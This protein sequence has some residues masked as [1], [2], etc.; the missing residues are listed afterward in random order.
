MRIVTTEHLVDRLDSDLAWRKKELTALGFVLK[1]SGA[2][3]GQAL[4]RGAVTL[5]YAH[6]EGYIKAAALG[7]VE[8]VGS[9]RLRNR[10]LADNFLAL[11]CRALLRSGAESGRIGP[12]L[13]VISFLRN[14][15][16]ERS[17][18]PAKSIE[19][20]SN[21]SSSVFREIT[22]VLGL[23]YEPYETKAVLID[24]SLLHARN[25]IAHGEYVLV[26]MDRWDELHHEVLTL[27]ESF[28]TDVMNAA[29]LERYRLGS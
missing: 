23:N 29:V 5:L 7:Y 22:A 26:T 20:R 2:D 8:F 1:T 6:W 12:H 25:T 10:E 19:T 11:A 27:L 21:L 24:E 4:L 13:D 9:R 15:L 14:R 18:L 3:R 17:R 28:R 16:E